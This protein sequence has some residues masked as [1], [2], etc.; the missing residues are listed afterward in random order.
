MFERWVD[1][2]HG[3]RSKSRGFIDL[4]GRS[5][6]VCE[7]KQTWQTLGS[8]RWDNA[9]LRAR[10]RAE[11]YASALP[12]TEDRPPF[13]VVTDFGRSLNGF[14]SMTPP[15]YGAFPCPM[16]AGL[17]GFLIRPAQSH[18]TNRRPRAPART[19]RP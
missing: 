5:A 1:F 18:S 7:A 3:D 4:Y 10:G 8:G 12:A 9:M 2:R 13:L 11:A 6:F 14:K 19:R 17:R 16:P 15:A